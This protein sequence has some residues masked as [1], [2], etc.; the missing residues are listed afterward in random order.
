MLVITESLGG[1]LDLS[2]QYKL[3]LFV[4]KIGPETENLMVKRYYGEDKKFRAIK[5]GTSVGTIRTLTK[6]IEK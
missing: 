6:E 1:I 2:K 4:H 5:E 3:S